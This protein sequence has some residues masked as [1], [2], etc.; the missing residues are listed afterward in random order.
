MHTLAEEYRIQKQE[1]RLV[2]IEVLYYIY[3]ICIKL[4]EIKRKGKEINTYC[5]SHILHTH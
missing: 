1:Y 2:T 4:Q 5:T 3:Y